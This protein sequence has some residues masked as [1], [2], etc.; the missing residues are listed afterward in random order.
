MKTKCPYCNYQ[1]TRH[2]TLD[3]ET[4]PKDDDI[5]FCINCGEVSKYKKGKLIK[6]D[7][8]TLDE[9]TKAEIREIETAWLRTR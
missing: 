8:N 1:A 5:S 4:C 3:R 9:Q 6:V 7:V 2:E